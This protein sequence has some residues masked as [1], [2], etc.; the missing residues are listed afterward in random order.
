MISQEGRAMISE[1]W[2]RHQVGHQR[3]GVF[4]MHCSSLFSCDNRPD[5]LEKVGFHCASRAGR[6]LR[7]CSLNGHSLQ[8]KEWRHSMVGSQPKVRQLLVASTCQVRV[9]LSGR[10]QEATRA[11]GSKPEHTCSTCC[12]LHNGSSNRTQCVPKNGVVTLT[13]Q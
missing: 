1:K 12:L 8:M 9:P 6:T 5:P 10:D 7:T 3:E 4:G 11:G 13:P 2:G